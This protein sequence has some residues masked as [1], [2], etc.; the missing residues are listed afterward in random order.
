[1]T[2]IEILALAFLILYV[3]LLIIN[4]RAFTKYPDS[5]TELGLGG[6]ILKSK[7]P[8]WFVV[9]KA[10]AFLAFFLI[11]LILTQFM[12]TRYSYLFFGTLIGIVGLNLVHDYRQYKR[13]AESEQ[14]GSY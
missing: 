7:G 9:T 14:K 12:P 3:L 11:S 5:L 6:S 1:M 10:V 4:Y 2:E 13:A 8:G